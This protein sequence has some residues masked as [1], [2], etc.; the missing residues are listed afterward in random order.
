MKILHETQLMKNQK[1]STTIL[2]DKA[3]EAVQTIDGHSLLFTLDD[4]EKVLNCIREVPGD[5]HGWVQVDLSSSLSKTCYN[6]DTVA[7]KAFDIAQ[8]ICETNTVDIVM[9]VTVGGVDYLHIVT[10]FENTLDNWSSNAPVFDTTT[11]FKFDYPAYTAGTYQA[12]P[13]NDVQILDSNDGN[14]MQYI[15]ADLV[16]D[17]G[18]QTITRFYI[19]VTKQH[20]YAWLPHNLQAT[21][22]AGKIT[23]ILGCGPNDGPNN[24][25]NV[26]GVY[27]LGT[28][29]GAAQ[30]FYTPTCNY[31]H[32]E[33]HASSTVFNLPAGYDSQYMAM[34]LS[35]SASNAPYTDIF[36]ASNGSLY[37][38]ANADQKDTETTN[39]T[40]TAIY[41]HDFFKNIQNIHVKNWNDNITIWGQSIDP[42][43]MKTSR[44][45]IMEGVAGQET[46][47]DAWSTPIILL[48]NVE[49]SSAYVDNNYSLDSSVDSNNGNAYG[50]C[51]VLFAHL[52]T[53]DLVK[54]F[55]DPVTSAWQERFLL[56]APLDVMTEI[57]D[58]PTY[59]THIEIDDDNNNPQIN[60]PVAIWSS[61]PCS[62]H[63]NDIANTDAYFKLD[64]AEPLLL[65]TDIT[66]NITIMQPVDSIG[67]IS[68]FVAVQD[69]AGK[70]TYSEAINPLAGS[71]AALQKKVPNGDKDYLSGAQVTAED[72]TTKPLVSSDYS[73]QTPTYSSNIYT[74]CNQNANL[75]Q[76]GLL[77]GNSWPD[78]AAMTAAFT[79][80]SVAANA[81]VTKKPIRKGRNI[82]TRKATPDRQARHIRFNPKTDKI[83]GWTFGK[84]AKH[85]EGIEAVKAL[86][87]TLNADG[88]LSL[89]NVQ[90]GSLFGWIEAKAGH[91]FKW[92]QSEADKLEKAVVTFTDGVIHCVLT[93]AGEVY[94]FVAKCANDIVNLVHTVLNA[95]KTA[96]DDI[97][98]WI[99]FLFDFDDILR[100]H[101]VTANILKVS[102]DD[103]VKNMSSMKAN[104]SKSFNSIV[105]DLNQLVGLPSL[106]DTQQSSSNQSPAPSS[107]KTPQAQWGTHK[108]K[109]NG[110]N[111]S[112]SS[113]TPDTMDDSVIGPLMT[114]LQGF[115]DNEQ[116]T[117]SNLQTNFKSIIDN[118]QTLTVTQIMEQVLAAIADFF[119]EE[120]EDLILALVDV[121]A[122]L[123]VTAQ[124]VM[125]APIEIPV[126][127]WLYKKI[128]K[129]SEF[130]LL[131][132]CC[133]ITAIPA[134][135]VYKLAEN[136]APFSQGNLAE[137]LSSAPDLKTVQ[138]ILSQPLSSFTTGVG[139]HGGSDP[140]NDTAFDVIVKVAN[141]SAMVGA[142]GTSVCTYMKSGVIDTLKDNKYINTAN[143]AFFML[144]VWPDLISSLKTNTTSSN[145]T[146]DF[147]NW[148]TWVCMGKVLTDGVAGFYG[149]TKPWAMAWGAV[150]SWADLV[151]NVAWQAPTTVAFYNAYEAYKKEGRNGTTAELANDIIEF[152]GGTFFDF[153]GMLSPALAAAS[154]SFTTAQ[155]KLAITGAMIPITLFNLIWGT[156]CILDSYGP[157]KAQASS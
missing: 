22:N 86:G 132:L 4:E 139:A 71:I 91:I 14:G 152:I 44:L 63:I 81:S 98:Q 25:Y 8:D 52:A 104:I 133:L 156:S 24:D 35:A 37:F 77:P 122:A 89:S 130:T 5:T 111:T 97:I 69:P 49:N 68:Y 16:S 3:F 13:I 134:T 154:S 18:A 116:T 80:T 73:S 87:L 38:L 102:I 32:P 125:T 107:A 108:L 138:A 12:M 40:P 85:F 127:S 26:G 46:N 62:V 59:S 103:A 65:K 43:D 112:C 1:A 92:V 148:C 142:V 157:F 129:G 143:T 29:N 34:A 75:N 106:P 147:N 84:D 19:D 9:A 20:G 144:Y 6:G 79:T 56:T 76:D 123:L 109:S 54:L 119:I 141:I 128:T 120:V 23:S 153:S 33:E 105:N 39:A 96:I 145:W 72:G 17:S 27:V 94:H 110:Q 100:T 58:T 67:G 146:D 93:I 83:Y 50:S 124:H 30:L 82:V 113:F 149:E 55:Q 99:G 135:I 28:V 136:E 137:Q 31:L 66:G 61:S 41:T 48:V 15:I 155:G 7:V 2:P 60:V 117:F 78:Q 64:T 10:G 51:N 45:F 101:S 57:F 11:Q 131:D 118:A 53:G 47:A 126:I 150:S 151:I 121:I 36:F 140:L 115:I 114:A 88:S 95:I 74:I 42:V 21:L 90:V 70:Q